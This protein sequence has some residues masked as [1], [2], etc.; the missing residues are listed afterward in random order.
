MRRRT[1]RLLMIM[2]VSASSLLLMAADW[3]QFRGPTSAGVSDEKGL[4]TTWDRSEKNILWK[5]PL[6]GFGASSPIVQD[7]RIYLTCYSGYGYDEEAPGDIESLEQYIVSYNLEDGSLIFDLP[8]KAQQPEKPYHGI[9]ALHGYSSGTPATDGK[10]LFAFFGMSGVGAITLSG[11]AL[12][13]Q[14]VGTGTHSHGS[15]SSPTLHKNLVIVNATVEY[16]ALVALD[17]QSGQGVWR[18]EEV[19][20]AWKTKLSFSTVN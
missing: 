19:K 10:H 8:L 9:Q 18:A 12:W 13:H 11:E 14:S 7:G 4:P 1:E 17:K 16:G 5:T 2:M 20:N 3:P 6:P 15:G